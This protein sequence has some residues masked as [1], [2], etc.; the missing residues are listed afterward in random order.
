[1]SIMVVFIACG[2]GTTSTIATTPTTSIPSVTTTPFIPPEPVS[3]KIGSL[4]RIFDIIAYAAQQEGVFQK[5]NLQVEVVS[6]RSTVEMNTALLSGELDGSIQGTFEAVNLNKEKEN[7]KLIGHNFM[8]RMFEIVV[9]PSSNINNPADLK[10]KEIA[11][12]TGTIMEYAA[13]ELF[14]SAGINSRD[15]TYTNVPNIALRVEMLNQGKVP[16]AV[17]TSPASDLAIINGNRVIL[18]DS[19]QLLGGPGLIFSV[20]ALNTKSNGIGRFVSAWQETVDLI[21]ANPAKYHDLLV[22]VAKVAEPVAAKIAVPVFPKLRLPAE[23]ELKSITDWMKAKNMLT[24][25]LPYDRVV[26]KRFIK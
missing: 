20:T 18:D 7:A 17:L 23:S 14:K 11:T 15:V 21:N 1:V 5:Y 13:D 10:G 9:S 3:L 22:T 24:E 8:P 16:A 4:P 26:D 19:K 2:T 25:D 6:F 12:G